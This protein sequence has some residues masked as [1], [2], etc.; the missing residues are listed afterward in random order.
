MTFELLR[1]EFQYYLDHQDELV[2]EY[3]GKVVVIKDGQVIGVYDEDIEAV[4]ATIK[5]HELGTFLVKRVAPGTESHTQV[6]H[7]RVRVT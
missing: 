6:Y 3:D 2:E 4:T 7:S 1:K 5:E